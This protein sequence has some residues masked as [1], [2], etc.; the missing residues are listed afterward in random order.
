MFIIL[1]TIRFVMKHIFIA[2]LFAAINIKIFT[3]IFG[4]TLGTLTKNAFRIVF[5]ET[6]VALAKYNCG[7]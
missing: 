5:F 4:Q 1:N 7:V 6:E 2:Y 3:Y